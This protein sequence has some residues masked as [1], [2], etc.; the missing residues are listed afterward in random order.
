MAEAGKFLSI[1]QVAERTGVSIS[2][3]RFY[4]RR[5]LVHPDRNMGGQRRFQ[6]ADLRRISFIVIAQQLGFSLEAISAQ[7]ASLPA[8]RAPTRQDWQRISSVFR[9]DL[10]QRIQRL[11]RLRDR[12]DGC[13]GCGCLSLENCQLYNP[14]DR[15]GSRGPGAQYVLGD[16]ED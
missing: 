4:E 9:G 13:I 12:L 3:L 5:G 15:A 2:A 10:E 8:A 1:G 14:Q 6:R 7:L 16:P 11:Q